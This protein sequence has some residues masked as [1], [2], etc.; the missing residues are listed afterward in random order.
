MPIRDLL[1]PEFDHEMANTRRVL[2]RV[3]EDRPDFRPHEK[4]MALGQ[5]A[6]HLAAVPN[7]AL[8]ALAR[9]EVDLAP[10]DGSPRPAELDPAPMTTRAALLESFDA[11]TRNARTHM[12]DVLDDVLMEKWTLRKGG[13]VVL[14]MPRLSVIRLLCLNHVI[15]HRAQLGVYLRL[16]D[17]PLPPIYGP[18]ADGEA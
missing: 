7:W 1:L 4:S 12:A 5:L 9:N 10:R 15:H 16:N 18:T 6:G 13:H 2:E 14:A 11:A 17:I 3:P 8:F